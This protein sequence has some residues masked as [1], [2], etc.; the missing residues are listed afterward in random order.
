MKA[1]DALRTLAEIT[2][3]QWGLVTSTQAR[4]AGLTH[5]DL[6]RLSQSGHLVRVAHGIYRDAGAPADQHE[7]LRAAWLSVSPAKLAYQRLRA[8]LSDAVVSGESAANLHAI[9]DFRA[10]AM[11]ISLSQRRRSRREGVQ[12]RVRDIEP[13][14]VTLV[15]GLPVTS[16]ERTI[17]DLA[18]DGHDLSHVANALSD[19]LRQSQLQEARLAELLAPVAHRRGFPQGDGDSLL[20]NLKEMAV[21]SDDPLASALSNV[22]PS[23]A[24]FLET[25][26]KSIAQNP[27]FARAVLREARR[28]EFPTVMR[29]LVPDEV[30]DPSEPAVARLMASAAQVVESNK[31]SVR[32][33]P[34]H[35]RTQETQEHDSKLD[36]K[37]LAASDPQSAPGDQGRDEDDIAT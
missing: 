33:A 28:A 23:W 17:A 4:E 37:R 34:R 11:E 20:R 24:L 18:R 14:D 3:T 19:A 22:P 36:R 15:Q 6:T 26:A 9:G 1:K 2:E 25:T 10:D 16:L 13:R 27:E 5:M 12:F 30:L 21:A 7:D 29:V 31:P 32:G 8:S 35:L